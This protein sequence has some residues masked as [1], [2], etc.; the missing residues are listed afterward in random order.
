M[1]VRRKPKAAQNQDEK[2]NQNYVAEGARVVKKAAGN[3]IGVAFSDAVPA[4]LQ[5]LQI[6][7]KY[8]R[9][10][11]RARKGRSFCAAYERISCPL[12]RF[13]LGIETPDVHDLARTLVGWSD[14][15]D[16]RTGVVFLENAPRLDGDFSHISFLPFP[17]P[18]IPPNL[19]IRI[20]SA[21]EMQRIVQMYAARTGLRTD[22]PISGIGAA[23]GECTAHVLT[24]DVPA[25][26]LGC[27]GSRPAIG[28][29]SGE[30]LLA[31]PA[32]N[33]IAADCLLNP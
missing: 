12:A 10:I 7:D 3:L 28:L 27:N 17:D 2:E 11:G 33:R 30:L 22:S 16:E 25:V 4:G 32:G 9:L 1:G 19:L 26:S 24:N 15:V 20:C 21:G 8:C 31:A 29:E 6:T 18:E 14:A 23:C 13:H 5:E